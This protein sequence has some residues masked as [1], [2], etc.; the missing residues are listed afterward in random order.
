[1]S[2]TELRIH[3]LDHDGVTLVAAEAG[4]GDPPLLFLHPTAADRNFFSPQVDEF[5]THHRVV[6][7]DQRGYGQSGQPDGP[8]G[9]AAFADDA[10]FVI[11]ALGLNRPVVVGSSMGGAVALELADRHPDLVRGIVVL[12]RS[13]LSSPATAAAITEMANGFRGPNAD[14]AVQGLVDS[15]I[16]PLD[17]PDLG[18]RYLQLAKG[19]PARVL[20]ATLEGFVDWDGEGALRRLG[21]PALFNFS[22]VPG[23]YEALDRHTAL[24]PH[25][26]IGHTV[27]AGHFD[28]IGVPD[29]VNSMIRRFLDVY[30]DTRAPAPR[31][32]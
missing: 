29:Q 32:R 14:G 28:H 12:N 16:G 23:N 9:P 17:P 27:G 5:S 13:V 30:V 11:D 25:V 8:Y 24:S 1:L 21:V 26:V 22:H 6:A 7:F 2:G 3:Q 19:V 31:D 18:P 20:A 4:S 10:A 15:Q